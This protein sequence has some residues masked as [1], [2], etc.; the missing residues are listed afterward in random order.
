MK[1]KSGFTLLEMIIVLSMTILILGMVTSVFMTGN[2]VFA[3]SDVKTTLQMEAKGIQEKL[4]DIC[5]EA[6]KE[7]T[8]NGDE[9]VFEDEKRQKTIINKNSNSLSILINDKDGNEVSKKIL[10]ENIK[11]FEFEYSD[12]LFEIFLELQ[13]D[14][15]FSKNNSYKIQFTITPRNIK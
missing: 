7:P 14:K 6:S 4:S 8:I 1:K 13:K 10:S 3:D 9:I 12:N 11:S 5:M 2:K 15:G